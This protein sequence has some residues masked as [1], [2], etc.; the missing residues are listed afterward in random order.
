[1]SSWTAVGTL[2]LSIDSIEGFVP[3]S[4]KRGGSDDA[5]PGSTMT[6]P[7]VTIGLAAVS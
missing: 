1:M 5:A 2:M 4:I 6:R 3:W 7:R